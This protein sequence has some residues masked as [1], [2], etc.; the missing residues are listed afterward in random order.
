MKV[1]GVTDI[2]L[3]RKR[4]EDRFIMSEK[5]G[6]FV[7]CDGMGGHKAG[8]VASSIAVQVIEKAIASQVFDHSITFLNTC[9]QKANRLIYQS[10]NEKQ[11]YHEM[12]TTIVAAVVTESNLRIANVGDSC[13]FLVRQDTITKITKDHTLAEQMIAE[14]ILKNE[15]IFTNA[16]NHILTRALG[17]DEEVRIDNFEEAIHPEDIILICSDGL[18]DMLSDQEILSIINANK[19]DLNQAARELLNQAL[20]KGGYDNITFIL[21]EL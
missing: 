12:G 17:Q 15:E 5:K 1:V 2:G 8:D 10:G 14:G 18:S 19:E 4:N 11:E 9:I 13:L 20:L 6:L 16:Y 21:V 3:V 7:V